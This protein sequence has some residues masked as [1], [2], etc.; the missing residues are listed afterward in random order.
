MAVFELS[1]IKIH[2]AFTSRILAFSIHL[3]NK[4]LS[5]PTAVHVTF[6]CIPEDHCSA[7]YLD[8]EISERPQLSFSKHRTNLFHFTP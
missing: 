5:N 1:L 3:Q 8:L 6:S 4:R 7:V 2:T